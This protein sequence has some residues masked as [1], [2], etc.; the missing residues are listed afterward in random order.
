MTTAAQINLVDPGVYERGGPPHEQFAWLREHAPV[1]W[2]EQDGAPG[3][4]GFWAV[5]RHAVVL[6]VSRHPEVFSSERRSVS[7]RELPDK[8]VERR[9]AMIL[10]MDPPRH[11]RQRGLVNRGFTPRMIGRLED[12]IRETCTRLLDAALQRGEADFVTDVAGPLPVEVICELVG[13]PPEDRSRLYELTNRMA[14]F[15]DPEVSSPAI[16][17][18]A[19]NDLYA[20]AAQ[21]GELRR[22]EPRDDIVTQLLQPDEDGNEL[23]AH[24]FNVFVLLLVLAGNETTRNAASGGMLA[25]FEH[26]QQWQRLLANPALIPTAAEELIRWVSPVNAFRRTAIQDTELAGQK[27]AEGDKVIIFYTSANRDEAIFR[28]P[29][30]FDIG[31]DPNPHIAFGFGPHFCLGRHLAALELRVLLQATVERMPAVT[32]DGPVTRF[33]SNFINGIKHMPVKFPPAAG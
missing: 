27:I 1:F 22:R 12:S 21:L 2:H 33:R 31:R 16:G 10:D 20:Y 8:V 26:P 15:D 29:Q 24:E 32:L 23:T 6:E 7:L 3:W 13:A 4:P 30:D 25:F 5:T 11:T 17:V 14:A 9:R 28:A 19:T 18:Q